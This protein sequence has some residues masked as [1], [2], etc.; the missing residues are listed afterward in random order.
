MGVPAFLY[1]PVGARQAVRGSVAWRRIVLGLCRWAAVTR[2]RGI[3]LDRTHEP[4]LRREGGIT[5]YQTE[6]LSMPTCLKLLGRFSSL[7]ASGSPGLHDSHDFGSPPLCVCDPRLWIRLVCLSRLLSACPGR[8]PRGKGRNAGLGRPLPTLS[9]NR[10]GKPRPG[11]QSLGC[12]FSC[13]S[14]A[15]GLPQEGV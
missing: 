1:M 8:G 2:V 11:V 4:C 10:H 5:W 9:R 13:F 3:V 15:L 12:W 14:R 6:P 7:L